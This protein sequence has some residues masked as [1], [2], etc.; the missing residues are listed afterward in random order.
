MIRIVRRFLKIDWHGR[1]RSAHVEQ[2]VD[3]QDGNVEEVHAVS[4]GECQACRRPL[5]KLDDT[6][7][8]CITCGRST[9]VACE[10]FCAV[11]HRP[12][13]GHCRRGF[14]ENAFSVCGDCL[15]DLEARLARQDKLLQDKLTF[16]RLMAL[17]AAEMKLIQLCMYDRSS[18]SELI[19]AFSELRLARK[20]ARLERK[21]TEELDNDH[22]LPP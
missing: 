8:V 4:V 7:G 11:C 5:E 14:P 6:R 18:I 12:V 15:T 1:V 9:C 3:H 13:C 19:A 22:R 21:L 16:E 17:G 20:L 2:L 10:H